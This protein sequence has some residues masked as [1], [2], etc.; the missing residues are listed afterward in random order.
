MLLLP[1]LLLQLFVAIEASKHSFGEER[2]KLD[3]GYDRDELPPSDGPLMIKASWNLRSILDIDEAK[4]TLSLDATFRFI[5]VDE[6]VTGILN[7]DED[8]VMINTKVSKILKMIWMPDVFIDQAIKVG[9]ENLY[10]TP[11]TIRIYPNHTIRYAARK[12]LKVACM[13]YFQQFPVDAQICNLTIHSFAYST[14]QYQLK[15]NRHNNHIDK[16]IYTAQF[17]HKIIYDD[18]F[19]MREYDEPQPG[20]LV[21][22]QLRRRLTSHFMQ[23]YLPSFLLVMTAYG[24][25]YLPPISINAR[26]STALITLLNIFT[27]NS[28]IRKIIPKV[29]YTTYLDIWLEGCFAIIFFVNFEYI[30]VLCFITIGKVKSAQNLERRCKI[31][32]PSLICIFTLTYIVVLGATSYSQYGRTDG[33]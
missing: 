18:D 23:G 32:V 5:W 31:V 2:F 9:T 33:N 22:F 24:S 25:L 28:G 3:P 6:R 21:Q 4:Q 13:M 16:D 27:L 14:D 20:L 29:A 10:L 26:G 30:W 12:T 8:F 1:K 17:Q 19:D 15:F 7:D 11:S